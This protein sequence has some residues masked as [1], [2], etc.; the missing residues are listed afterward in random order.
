M[1][2][3]SWKYNISLPILRRK[4]E[5]EKEN[6]TESNTGAN[7]DDLPKSHY[8]RILTQWLGLL[9]MEFF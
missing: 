7:K 3:F 6:D 5:K 8:S 1:L 9:G 2:L 4:R